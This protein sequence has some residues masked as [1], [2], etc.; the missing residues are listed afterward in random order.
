MQQQQTEVERCA[1]AKIEGDT[2]LHLL[3][4]QCQQGEETLAAG[5]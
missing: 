3:V 1:V 5:G 4:T 2:R